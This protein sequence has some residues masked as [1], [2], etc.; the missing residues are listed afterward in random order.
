MKKWWTIGE[1]WKTR[2]AEVDLRVGGK[3]TLGNEPA[4]GSILLITGEYLV[5]EPPD[6]LVYTWRFQGENPEE[7]LITVE[8][9]GDGDKTEIVVTHER[10]SKE[11]AQGAI[12]GWEAVQ[13]SL[14]AFSS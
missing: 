7:S 12:A 14:E 6:R 8:F 4:G 5:V 3:F 11:M 1:G 13:H 2:F 10:A 9:K